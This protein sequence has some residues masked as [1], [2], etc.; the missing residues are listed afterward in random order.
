MLSIAA[1][2]LNPSEAA[3]ASSACD[4]LTLKY[5]SRRAFL[6]SAMLEGQNLIVGL[7]IDELTSS[8]KSADYPSTFERKSSLVNVFAF[9]PGSRFGEA[10]GEK[11]NIRLNDAQE[12]A[13]SISWFSIYRSRCRICNIR[14]HVIKPVTEC[15]KK[16]PVCSRKPGLSNARNNYSPASAES[17]LS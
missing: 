2:V 4:E 3:S 8:P 9:Q 7:N 10:P 5:C 12:N 15:S 1:C 11:F 13:R 14:R 17:A 6:S 16:G